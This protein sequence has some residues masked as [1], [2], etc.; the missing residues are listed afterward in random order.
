[1]FAFAVAWRYL[2]SNFWQ[3]FLLIAGV[4]LGV[5]AYVFITALVQGLAI[6]LTDDVTGKSAHISLEP[7]TRFARILTAPDIRTESVALVSTMQRKQ[8]RTWRSTV[9][10]VLQQPEVSAISPQITGNAFLIKG[11]SVAPVSVTS[12]EP[13]DLDVITPISTQIISGSASLEGGGV[14]VGARLAE[15]LGLSAS[16]PVL[17]R[18]DRDV[19]RLLIVR[20]VFRTGIRDFDERVAIISINTARPLF[21]LPD[22]IT[23]IEIKLRDPGNARPLAS[24]LRDATG[25]QATPWQERN[26]NLDAA[27][28]AQAR[29]GVLIQMFSLISV[30]VG[31]ASALMLSAN[32]RRSEIG[33]MRA[34]GVS[35]SFVAA[36]F[37]FQGLLIGLI[38]AVLGCSTGYG[39]CLWLASLTSPDGTMALPIAPDKGGYLMVLFLTTLG[40]VI[41]SFLPARAAA[42]LDPLEAI[43][44]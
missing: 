35:G 22:G 8:I 18:T 41:A 17:F 30:L 34:F 21:L 11:A 1:M 12:V 4:A 24:F 10:L 38:G 6:R 2:L 15:T 16:Q 32:R 26:E 23:N 37:I 7:P 25:L 43:Q 13:E 3:T 19:D 27:L 29:T 28:I 42:R 33:I 40:S 39:L 20:G 36:V 9:Q 14:L 5:T 44:Q 31:I